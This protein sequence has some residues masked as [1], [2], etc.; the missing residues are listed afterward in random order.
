VQSPSAVA[1]SL[2]R[3]GLLPEL[4]QHLRQNRTALREEWARRI[5]QA[6]L[7]T[8]MTPQEIFSGATSVYDTSTVQAPH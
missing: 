6:R 4:V 2:S 7:L 1:E 8:A 5:T 3:N